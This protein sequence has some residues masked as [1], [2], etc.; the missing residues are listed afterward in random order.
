MGLDIEDVEHI[1]NFLVIDD[2]NTYSLQDG[3]WT[4]VRK[5]GDGPNRWYMVVKVLGLTRL[6]FDERRDGRPVYDY[7][8]D[9]AGEKVGLKDQIEE[10]VVRLCNNWQPL[11]GVDS[12]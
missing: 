12:T 2:Q 4:A 3:G 7:G 11:Q 1:T 5:Y 6:Q 10:F 8:W 9:I